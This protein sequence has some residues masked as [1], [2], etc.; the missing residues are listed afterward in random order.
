MIPLNSTTRLTNEGLKGDIVVKRFISMLVILA[1]LI[2]S[3]PIYA[4][5]TFHLDENS[6]GDNEIISSTVF[7]DNKGHKDRDVD[8]YADIYGGSIFYNKKGQI[9]YVLPLGQEELTYW[10][11]NESFIGG[12]PKLKGDKETKEI[13]NLLLGDTK[14]KSV[15]G[16]QALNLGEV[17]E[18]IEVRD[19]ATVDSVE[20]YY[21]VKPGGN[22]ED[23]LVLVEGVDQ[24]L[25]N[26]E[27]ELIWMTE[28]GSLKLSAPYAYDLSIL[29]TS[30]SSRII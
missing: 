27:G 11:F 4:E 13:Y 20:R 7:F 1:L 2:T 28:I 14:A 30:L 8:F 18:N 17:Y 24:L 25:I 29:F 26:D 19:V 9:N 10:S 21:T 15:K 12:E 5:T 23:I 22:H 6:S 16:Y 3:M